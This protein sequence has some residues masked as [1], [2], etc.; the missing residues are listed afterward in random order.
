MEGEICV[1]RSIIDELLS[2][3]LLK[4][5]IKVVLLE[6]SLMHFILR[7]S[8]DMKRNAKVVLLKESLMK[9]ILRISREI[10]W[11]VKVV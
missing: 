7:I 10:K 5:K 8:K 9:L 2:L 3:D 11:K 6:R 1:T 4:W